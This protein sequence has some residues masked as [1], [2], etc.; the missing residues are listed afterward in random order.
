MKKKI[1]LICLLISSTCLLSQVNENKCNSMKLVKNEAN[2]NTNYLEI[3][4]SYKEVL[5]NRTKTTIQIPIV[6]HIVH[7]NSHTTIGSGTNISNEQIEDAIRILNEDYSKTNPEFP[8]PPRNTFVNYAGN[9]DLKFCLATIDPNGNTTTGITRTA[10]TQLNWDADDDSNS[11]CH[12]AN[13][14]KKD[15]CGG[16]D[17][18]DP[19]KYLNIWICDLTNSQSNGMTLG[20]AYLPGLLADFN[21]SND[22]KDGLVVDYRYFGTIGV[23]APSSDGRTAT[24]EIG[25]YLGLMHTFCESTDSQGNLTCC[26]K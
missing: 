21:S 18:W 10:T 26:D 8:N 7:R 12:E 6:I 4:E 24:H 25:H 11:A 3:L 15:A 19:S 22:Y 13:G 9:A 16:K 23:A 5:T 17:G 1:L 14:M 20:Y 2:R